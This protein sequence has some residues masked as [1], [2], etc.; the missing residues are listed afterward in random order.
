M[1]KDILKENGIDFHKR[2]IKIIP[3]QSIEQIFKA[4]S[5]II[6][7]VNSAFLLITSSL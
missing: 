5:I 4:N 6:F 2:L 3:D 7:I 1:L